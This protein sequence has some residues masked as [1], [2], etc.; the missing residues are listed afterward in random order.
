MFRRRHNS[1]MP[2]TSTPKAR[3][4]PC[5]GPVD[6]PSV[7]STNNEQVTAMESFG[8]RATP[9]RLQ[10][11]TNQS[12]QPKASTQPKKRDLASTRSQSICVESASRFDKR[13]RKPPVRF[14]PEDF[15]KKSKQPSEKVI[16]VPVQ[17]TRRASI[18][19]K[20]KP[21]R[22]SVA[23]VAE[24][25]SRRAS[26]SVAPEPP[27]VKTSTR[28]P[29]TSS[30]NGSTD[31]IITR[32]VAIARCSENSLPK[33]S[34]IETP[35]YVK[36]KFPGNIS[37]SRNGDLATMMKFDNQSGILH[38]NPKAK[39]SKRRVSDEC[40]FVSLSLKVSID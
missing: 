32:I 12:T 25:K 16:T 38:V 14:N 9:S 17:K 34:P 37:A 20:P 31:D 1:E 33:K 6:G 7:E 10:V 23:V 26:V 40:D 11:A 29:S 19:A 3:Q 35:L 30:A 21:R 28:R 27:K 18:A 39:M 5:N 15:V 24:T 2:V 13:A 22:P 4:E 8:L 36:G